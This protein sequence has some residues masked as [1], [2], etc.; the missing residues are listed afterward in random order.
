MAGSLETIGKPDAGGREEKAEHDAGADIGARAK[1]FARFQHFGTFPAETGE[2][3]VATEK[4]DGDGHAPFGRNE[5]AIQS[6]LSDEPE[7]E[8][9]SEIDKQSAVGKRAAYFNLDET[10]KSVAGQCA[11]RAE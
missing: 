6:D 4:A 7:K 10:L 8:A 3:G 9:A 2:G 1:P 11:D 5:H